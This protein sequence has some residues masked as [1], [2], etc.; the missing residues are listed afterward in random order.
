M[1]KGIKTFHVRYTKLPVCKVAVKIHQAVYKHDESAGKTTINLLYTCTVT[2][3]V[4][5]RVISQ[6]AIYTYQWWYESVSS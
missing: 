6:Y 1:L 3:G 2:H 4:R 5:N